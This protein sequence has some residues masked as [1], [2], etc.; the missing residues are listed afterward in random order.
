MNRVK[1]HA[2][3]LSRDISDLRWEGQKIKDKLKDIKYLSFCTFGFLVIFIFQYLKL[4]DADKIELVPMLW[5][6]VLMSIIE[7]VLTIYYLRLINK[8][9]ELVFDKEDISLRYSMYFLFY[10][11]WKNSDVDLYDLS[12]NLNKIV[13]EDE[14]LKDLN[15]KLQ[16]YLRSSADSYTWQCIQDGIRN[17]YF[18]SLYGNPNI[19]DLGFNE[20][21]KKWMNSYSIKQLDDL[22][23]L[24][25]FD[26]CELETFEDLDFADLFRILIP[27]VDAVENVKKKLK[28]Y[29]DDIKKDDL[30]VYGRTIGKEILSKY[31][32]DS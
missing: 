11:M 31:N 15:K 6:L 21:N 18:F 20:A 10:D 30:N 29:R 23:D 12:I 5:T 13:G 32:I 25:Y 27:F 7:I 4:S 8:N 1:I 9:S 28:C 16:L 17:S 14:K 3:D 24:S 2:D 26:I 22:V 19:N